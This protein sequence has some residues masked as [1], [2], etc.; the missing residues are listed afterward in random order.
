MA[1]INLFPYSVVQQISPLARGN[2]YKR[3]YSTKTTRITVNAAESHV[4]RSTNYKPSSWSFDHIQSLS[5][6]YT[7][8]AYV[9]RANTLKDAVKTMILKAGN[10]LRILELVDE[11]QRLGI[12]YLFEEEISNLLETIYYNY[13]KFPEN[14]N[15]IDLNIKALGFRLL[16]QHG[17]HVPQ[18]I[19]LNFK[20]KTQNLNSYLLEDVVG[21][22][23]LYEACYYSFEDE[24]ILDD[25]RDITTKYLKESLEKIDGSIFSLVSHALE[26]PLHW[27]VPRVESKWFIELYEKRGGASPTLIELAKLDFDM[28]QAIHLEDLKHASRWWRNT[29]WDTKLTFARDMLVE[30]FLWTVGFSYSP[31]FSHGR[32]TITKVAAMITTLDD[33]YGVFG[34]LGELEQFTDVINRWDIKAIEKLP[35]HMKICFFGL[36]NSINDITHETLANKGFLILPYLKKAWADLCKAYLVEAQWYHRGHIP[37]LNEYLDNACVSISGPVAL[38]HVHF[39]TSVSSIKEI[40]HCINRTENIVSYASLIFRLTDD[41]GTS[42]GEMAIGDTLKSI[43]LY[44]HETVATEPE[45]RS[46]IQS[47]IDKTWK[48]LNKE[49]AIVNSEASREFIDYATNLARLAQLMYGEGDEDFRLD[50]IKSHVLSLLFTPIQG[51]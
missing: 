28:V 36:Y 1:S 2:A 15:K 48:K 38:M 24:S 9:A 7:G 6:K 47:L 3:I 23:N 19:F 41:L 51:I 17:Y 45:A 20:E 18:E 42:L 35:D 34:T 43:Q 39:L 32:R 5:S 12:S 4:R 8:D 27:R 33:V 44:M 11:L 22:L 21:M 49:R 29:S 31:N 37:T 25:A 13:Y 26:Q 10:L 40:H 50:V 46:Y 16:R 14:W 30:N